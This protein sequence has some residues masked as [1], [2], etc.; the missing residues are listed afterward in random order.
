MTEQETDSSTNSSFNQSISVSCLLSF[1]QDATRDEKLCYLLR[2][3]QLLRECRPF[4]P[5]YQYVQLLDLLTDCA[6]P[7]NQQELID[8]ASSLLSDLP[9]LL[10]PPNTPP[11][12]SFSSDGSNSDSD[13][14]DDINWMDSDDDSLDDSELSLPFSFSNPSAPRDRREDM[15]IDDINDP[16]LGDS[17]PYIPLSFGTAAFTTLRGTEEDDGDS[18]Q[19]SFAS[20]LLTRSDYFSKQHT[21]FSRFMAPPPTPDL[22]WPRGN[23]E[24]HVS[25]P[26]LGY[27]AIDARLGLNL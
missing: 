11:S 12:P 1:L 17:V 22:G 16:I 9:D 26:I 2:I 24:Q 6:H 15:N 7:D 4:V 14:F 13:N 18:I 19:D 5:H 8:E 20:P 21:L 3:S 27:A 10:P 25:F 23:T